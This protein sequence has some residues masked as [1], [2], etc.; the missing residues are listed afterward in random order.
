MRPVRVTPS[1][2]P[3]RLTEHAARGGAAIMT[4]RGFPAEAQVVGGRHVVVLADG[5]RVETLEA[6]S[7]V[8]KAQLAGTDYA[9]LV[10]K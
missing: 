5:S 9:H 7:A 2:D 10:A 6:W 8:F 1:P 3:K 4:V